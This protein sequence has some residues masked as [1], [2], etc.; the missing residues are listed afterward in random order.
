MSTISGGE[1]VIKDKEML[2]S[3]YI[4]PR[5]RYLAQIGDVYWSNLA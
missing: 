4:C 2:P 5:K 1:T 3:G